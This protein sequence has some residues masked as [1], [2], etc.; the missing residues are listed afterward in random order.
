MSAHK[1]RRKSFGKLERPDKIIE[2]EKAQ[3]AV[4]EETLQDSD[5][6]LEVE[7]SLDK[8]AFAVEDTADNKE[9]E[10]NEE[11]VYFDNAYAQMPDFAEVIGVSFR[12]S[13]KMY[14]FAANGCTAKDGDSAIVETA[15]G[16]EYGKVVLTNKMVS[17]KELVLPLKNVIR[18]ADEN[19][20]AR[21][22][23][24]KKKED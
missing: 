2:R 19:D 11:P 20:T 13:G 22:E 5:E 7:D 6:E 8:T 18:I 15:R 1:N 4:S 10:K 9:S 14:Y 21:F 3:K 16:V 24:N 17:K 12:G 23:E